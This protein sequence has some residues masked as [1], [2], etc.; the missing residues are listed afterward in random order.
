M[1]ATT[2][3]KGVFFVGLMAGGLVRKTYA[4]RYRQLTV[5]QARKESPLVVLFMALWG[6]AGVLGLVYVFSPWLSFAD[7]ALPIWTG[8]L[9]GVVFAAGVWLL[10]RSHADLGRNWTSTLQIME[11]HTLVTGGVY[12]RLRHPMYAAHLWW[13]LGQ[14]LLLPNWLAGPGALVAFLPLYFLRFPR[15]EAQLLDRFGDDYRAYMSRT[16]RMLPKRVGRSVP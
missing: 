9:G 8:W 16:G 7:Y 13:S 3:F 1:D 6:V 5:A 14:L 10:W 2:I 15:E 4:R 11:G 12:R